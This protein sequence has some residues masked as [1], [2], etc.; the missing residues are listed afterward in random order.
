MYINITEAQF[1][2]HFAH[3]GH[4]NPFSYSALVALHEYYEGLEKSTGEPI[5]LDVISLC[6]AWTEY[7][8]ESEMLSDQCCKSVEE[9]EERLPFVINFYS[10][11]LV[12]N[13]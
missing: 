11:W 7:S 6:C 3:M 10:G 13:F 2:D 8:D 12:P 1:I 9:L 4:A 5:E